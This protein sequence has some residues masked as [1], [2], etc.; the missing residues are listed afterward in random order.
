MV[1]HGSDTSLG[2]LDRQIPDRA[3]VV[4]QRPDDLAGCCH[5]RELFIGHQLVH[6]FRL[7]EVAM[8]EV[9]TGDSRDWRLGISDWRRVELQHDLISIVGEPRLMVNLA[10]AVD[11][12]V[13]A[14]PAV[15]HV[16]QVANNLVGLILAKG[17]EGR[18][19]AHLGQPVAGVPGV[20]A[21][22]GVAGIQDTI[23]VAVDEPGN[24]I[25]FGIVGV[26]IGAV[27][28]ELAVGAGRVGGRL[29]RAMCGIP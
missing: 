22:V 6:G 15:L 11:I 17:R 26:P 25:A 9:G 29:S 14:D 20:L 27:G 12:D 10:V 8:G 24:P 16:V 4:G 21:D 1:R 23:F 3:K 13:S 19:M 28:E 2:I 5:V 7:P 18:K